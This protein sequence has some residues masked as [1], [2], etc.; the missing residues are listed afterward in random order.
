M[1]GD[2]D[3]S[4]PAALIA[5]RARAAVVTALTDTEALPASELA[6]RAGVS[7][8]T[9]SAHLARLVEGGLLVSET[10]GRHR[11]F[12][13]SS[14]AVARAVEALAIIAPARTARS[15]RESV[16]GEALRDARTCYDH[17]AGRLGVA[18]TAALLRDR[19]IRSSQGAYAVTRRGERA[20]GELGIDVQGLRH[21][22]RV[23]ARPCLDWSERQ[24]HL[25]GSLGAALTRRLFEM[26]WIRRPGVGR[27]VRL[28]PTGLRELRRRFNL[29]V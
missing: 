1:A 10:R 13:L 27:A 29:D 6:R 8:S 22:H 23:L 21:A 17:L 19:L 5:E 4:V 26:A 25:A 7:N 16:V 9:A 12:R 14:P 24:P 11:Y 28:T 3:I 18:M 20:L 2:A 15:L